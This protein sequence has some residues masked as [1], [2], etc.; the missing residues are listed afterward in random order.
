MVHLGN[1]WDDI[2]ASEFESEYYKRIRYWLKKEYAEQTIYPPMEDIFNALRYTP[3]HAVKAVLLGQDPYHGPGQAH[4]LC[5]SVQEGVEPPPSLRNIFQELESD[6]GF[7]PPKN[8]TLTKWAEQG[9]LMLN[10]TLTVRRGQANSHKNIGWTTFTD[11]VIR[12]LNERE[13]PIV[14]LLWG[15]NARSKKPLI[16][17]PNH[18]ILETVHPSPLSAYGGFFGCRHFSRCNEFLQAHGETP[19]DWNLNTP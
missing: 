7:P 19:I 5:F 10:T 4:G 13:T 3:Y 12:R 18:L 16:T 8:G 15:G 14:F 2:L 6:L 9:V 1:D 11:A 17:N